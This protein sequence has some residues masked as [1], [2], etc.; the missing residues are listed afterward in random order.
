M[1]SHIQ[2]YQSFPDFRGLV[3]V[4]LQFMTIAMCYLSPEGVVL[5][6]DSTASMLVPV[7]AMP[8]LFGIHF[9]NYAQKLFQ[10][11]EHG[12]MGIVAW[13]LSGLPNKGLRTLFAELSDEFEKNPP[14]NVNDATDVWIDQFWPQ[15]SA[16]Y[17]NEIA[18]G[19][20]LDGK[21]PFDRTA[22]P[23]DPA[24]RTEAEENT[25]QNIKYGL[26]AGYCI[27]GYCPPGRT[28]GACKVVFDP[29]LGK[30]E[31]T[32]LTPNSYIFEGAPNVIRRLV[33]GCDDE[34]R[35]A[36]LAS[37]H[38][39]GAPAD[40][41]QLIQ[42]YKFAHRV[43]PMRDTIDFVH[44]C[45]YSTIK[46]LK[47]SNLFQIC[48]GPI[49]VAAITTDRKFRWVRHKEWD[50]AITEGWKNDNLERGER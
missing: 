22:A 31:S 9:L 8:G 50:A 6:A 47:F 40:L 44:A 1:V 38:W 3:I 48:G 28:P 13:N 37:P 46:G 23:P 20:I 43:L 35:T 27:G 45:I 24:A 14:K 4:H 41:D 19:K 7:P 18:T 10:L 32:P 26:V 21:N 42:Q 33:D 12:T 34:L 2:A 30:P 5:G 17:A 49:E 39:K 16:A 25:L 29:L 15:Y 11:G 36:I